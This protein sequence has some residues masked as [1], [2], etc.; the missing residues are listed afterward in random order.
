MQSTVVVKP[1]DIERTWWVVDAKGRTLGRLA[2]EVAKVLRGKHKAMYSPSLDVGDYVIVVN[3]QDIVL[4][5]NKLQD[6]MYYRHSGYLGGLKAT[7]A[8]LMHRVHPERMVEIAIKGML[9][10]TRLGRQMFRKLK[11]YKGNAHP[12]EAQ[13][14]KPL[15]F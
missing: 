2:S 14:P 12:H 1:S 13:T 5:G 4:T 9:P 6:K 7:Q 15:A 11:V 8:S 3:A 10:K